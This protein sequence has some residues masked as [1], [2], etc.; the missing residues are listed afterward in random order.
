MRR[1]F[2]VSINE[3]GEA[4]G[5]CTSAIKKI[6]RRH[7]IARW[8]H[9]KIASV[10][11]SIHTIQHRIRELEV[12]PAQVGTRRERASGV[13]CDQSGVSVGERH[14]FKNELLP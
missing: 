13:G 5:M 2:G 10:E 7:G 14:S 9:R 1:Y 8:P 6:C 12:A 4:L 11:K 3:A